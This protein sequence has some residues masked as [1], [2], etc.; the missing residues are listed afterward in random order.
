MD[1]PLSHGSTS[2]DTHTDT[3]TTWGSVP[4]QDI[5]TFI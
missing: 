4:H 5:W 2:T 1:K 3:H